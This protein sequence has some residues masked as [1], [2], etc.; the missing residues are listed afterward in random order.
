M[1]GV[2]AEECN[3]HKGQILAHRPVLINVT[4]SWVR[5]LTARVVQSCT[6]LRTVAAALSDRC[7]RQSRTL[8]EVLQRVTGSSVSELD[9][10]CHT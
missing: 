1:A 10:P 5:H 9:R 4:A 3:Q 2:T 6:A 8:Q 7:E